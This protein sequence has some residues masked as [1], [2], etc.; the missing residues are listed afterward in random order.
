M[1]DG[2]NIKAAEFF[3]WNIM[4][5]CMYVGAPQKHKTAKKSKLKSVR[6]NGMGFAA[7]F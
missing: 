1:I 2:F 7:D 4:K 3:P 6:R 5:I